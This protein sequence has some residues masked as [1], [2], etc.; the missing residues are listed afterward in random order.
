MNDYLINLKKTDWYK[1]LLPVLG[2]AYFKQINNFLADCYEGPDR[3]FPP[4]DKIF[5]AMLDTSLADTKVIIV[6]QDPY[7]ELGQA[8]GLSF[9]VPDDFPAPSSLQN[10]HKEIQTD[11]GQARQ[12]HDLIPWA[13]QGVLLLNSVLTV[14]E[15][16]AN[17][18]AGL[19]WEKFTDSVIQL[20]SAEPQPKV[21]ILWGNFARRKASLI[22]AEKD[23]ILQSAHPSGLSANRGFFGSRPFSQTNDW[24]QAHGRNAIN[25]LK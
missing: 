1:H 24:L 19:I 6:G 18:H 15:H 13:K 7:H 3:V 21:F 11:L 25:W 23:L 9:S 16:Q 20:A 2:E 8:Q 12:S 17:S 14:K 22:D 5:S 4:A 10:I